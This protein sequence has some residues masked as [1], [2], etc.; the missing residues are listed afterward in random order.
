MELLVNM[1]YI[2]LLA[3]AASIGVVGVIIIEILYRRNLSLWRERHEMVFIALQSLLMFFALNM[4]LIIILNAFG[5]L[6]SEAH[7]FIATIFAGISVLF[8]IVF[9]EHREKIVITIEKELTW[10]ELQMQRSKDPV[11][12]LRQRIAYNLRKKRLTQDELVTLLEKLGEREAPIGDA[13]LDLRDRLI[14][15]GVRIQ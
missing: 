2:E 8:G 7:Q 12:Y 3:I 14:E 4:V 15:D 10:I 6:W 5:E 9:L 11:S 13:A 1:D